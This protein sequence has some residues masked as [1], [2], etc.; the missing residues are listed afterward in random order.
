MARYT[1]YVVYYNMYVGP[2]ELQ[3]AVFDSNQYEY[4]RITG[5]IK[6][7]RL[8]KDLPPA[9]VMLFQHRSICTQINSFFIMN[10]RPNFNRV[11]HA[12]GTENALWL[13]ELEET[14]SME[15][16]KKEFNKFK[17]SASFINDQPI[18]WIVGFLIDNYKLRGIGEPEVLHKTPV[19][20]KNPVVR[21]PLT[22]YYP[23]VHSVADSLPLGYFLKIYYNAM[24]QE[25]YPLQLILLWSLLENIAGCDEG[26]KLACVRNFLEEL[27]NASIPNF[28]TL[29]LEPESDPHDKL[30]LIYELRNAIIHEGKTNYKESKKQ[31]EPYVKMIKEFDSEEQM[32]IELVK[33]LAHLIKVVL[34]CLIIKQYK[35]PNAKLDIIWSDSPN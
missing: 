12:Q 19:L 15:E 26:K 21:L 35:G 30:S 23:I 17:R 31:R 25:E 8:D 10:N 29:L 34:L 13:F 18:V 14:E 7:W 2:E 32:Y 24:I 1:G 22:E 3:K 4:F 33:L 5:C 28:K 20:N 27:I 6:L 11:E 9:Y 16:L